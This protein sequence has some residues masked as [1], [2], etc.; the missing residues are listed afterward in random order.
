MIALTEKTIGL[1]IPERINL[2]MKSDYKALSVL[3]ETEDLIFEQFTDLS[4]NFAIPV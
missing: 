3:A 2:V 1:P 4:P